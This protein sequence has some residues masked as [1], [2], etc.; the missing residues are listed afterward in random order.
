M[1]T[2][3]QWILAEAQE[4]YCNPLVQLC[5]HSPGLLTQFSVLMSKAFFLILSCVLPHSFFDKKG[6]SQKRTTSP[7][8]HQINSNVYTLYPYSPPFL[9]LHVPLPA[10]AQA[11]QFYHLYSNQGSCLAI[12]PLLCKINFFLLTRIITIDF[13][14]CLN[15]AQTK[16]KNKNSVDILSSGHYLIFLL[17]F[18]TTFQS[19]FYTFSSSTHCEWGSSLS[20]PVSELHFFSAYQHGFYFAKSGGLFPVLIS[21]ELLGAFDMV[22]HLSSSGGTF[23]FWPPY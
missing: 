21:L 20:N 23:F 6:S 19:E 17:T 5:S 22:D 11:P 1:T 10:Y 12:S 7:P 14:I 15:I 8:H 4:S 2:N 16:N 18:S 13:R 3:F 9:F